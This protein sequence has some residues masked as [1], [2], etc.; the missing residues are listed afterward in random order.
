MIDKILELIHEIGQKNQEAL[1]WLESGEPHNAM[2][3]LELN[4][5]IVESVYRMTKEL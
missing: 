5:E 3:T 2:Q 4:Y 1:H